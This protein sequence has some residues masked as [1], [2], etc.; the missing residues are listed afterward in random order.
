MT[1]PV[2]TLV[3][4][5]TSDVEFCVEDDMP[6]ASFTVTWSPPWFD[7]PSRT[8][9]TPASLSLRC[10]VMGEI[11]QNMAVCLERGDRVI[12]TGHLR[13]RSSRTSDGERHRT[14]QLAVTDVGASLRFTQVEVTRPGRAVPPATGQ[15]EPPA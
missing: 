8:W 13:Q 12:V 3:G 1:D 9:I 15:D 5:L 4:N 14:I 11:A 7:K 2:T 10:T 6:E